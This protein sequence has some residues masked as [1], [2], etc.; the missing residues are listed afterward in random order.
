MTKYRDYEAKPLFVERINSLIEDEKD[1]EEYWRII[2]TRPRASIR[3]NTLKISPEDLKARLESKGWEIE[4]PFPDYKE[5]MILKS[6]LNPGELGKAIEHILGYYYVQEISSMLPVLALKP[7]SQ[8]IVL[9]LC[10]SP[11]SKTTQ[12]AASMGNAGTIL[13]ND[14]D[15]GRIAILQANLERV[16]ASNVIMARHDA[17]Q[18]CLKLEKPSL[19]LS[20]RNTVCMPWAPVLSPYQRMRTLS[21]RKSPSRDRACWSRSSVSK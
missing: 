12:M 15:I 21:L 7:S 13:A 14:K 17:V 16:G 6:Q 2:R 18:L 8:D 11:G 5:I 3:C 20:S 19:D 9:D 4:Q 10:A 1:K